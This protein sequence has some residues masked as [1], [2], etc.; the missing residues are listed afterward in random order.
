MESLIIQLI[1]AHNRGISKARSLSF[2]AQDYIYFKRREAVFLAPEDSSIAFLNKAMRSYLR[3]IKDKQFTT[4][5][6][7]RPCPYPSLAQ[8]KHPSGR[9]L[10]LPSRSR[11]WIRTMPR[12]SSG[13]L[14]PHFTSI[15]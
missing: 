1:Y 2:S 13:N 4:P 6:L 9:T 15:T 3:Q 5:T 14:S 11:G 10:A 12:H 8:T 7:S